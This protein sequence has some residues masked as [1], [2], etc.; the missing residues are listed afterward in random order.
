M[1]YP[2]NKYRDGGPI[3]SLDTLNNLL[4]RGDWVCWRGKPKHPG[5]IKHMTFKT[6]TDALKDFT[7]TRAIDQQKEYNDKRT[8]EFIHGNKQEVKV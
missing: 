4:E 7:I 5:F 6:V 1:A 3:Y 8:Q 2:K